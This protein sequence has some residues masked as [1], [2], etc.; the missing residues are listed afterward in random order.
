MSSKKHIQ[1]TGS[2]NISWKDAI[3]RT[4]EEASET[5]SNLNS[6]IVIEQRAKIQGNKISEYYVDLDLEF[7]IDK[8]LQNPSNFNLSSNQDE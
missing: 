4:I 8:R 5:L 7:E 6:I 3:V 2:S 1:I